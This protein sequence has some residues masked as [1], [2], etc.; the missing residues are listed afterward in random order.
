MKE[1]EIHAQQID[2]SIR[3][4]YIFEKF[5]ELKDGES[6]IV[7]NNHDPKPLIYQFRELRDGQFND[8]YLEKG[9]ETWRVKLQKK[10]KTGC[11]G[12]CED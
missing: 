4:S 11:C 7:I 2:A 10:K 3:H 8:E 1:V 6:I 9:P 12:F 5:D